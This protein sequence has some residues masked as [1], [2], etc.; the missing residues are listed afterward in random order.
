M[1]AEPEAGVEPAAFKDAMRRLAAGV[2]VVT[3]RHG[4]TVNGMTATAVCSVSA[5]PPL[6][7]VTLN[8]KSVS[9]GLISQ[10]GVF[11]LNFLSAD[12]AALAQYFASSALKDFT[13]VEHVLGE[14]GCPLLA[15]CVARMECSVQAEHAHGSH[16]IFVGLVRNASAAR[17]EALIYGDG[18]FRSLGAEVAC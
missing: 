3:S 11:A 10:S 16:T 14:T 8:R 18:R 9:H 2:T 1:C 4:A 5:E 13:N 17:H 7:L 6:V 15:G 12:Q